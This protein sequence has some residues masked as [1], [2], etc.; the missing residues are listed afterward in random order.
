MS[1]E[2]TPGLP[3][4]WAPPL[5][6]LQQK[7]WAEHPDRVRLEA[8]WDERD[9]NGG[10]EWEQGY[11]DDPDDETWTVLVL[12]TVDPRDTRPNERIGRWPKSVPEDAMARAR[13]I[14]DEHHID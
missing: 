4:D 10:K 8:L 5:R 6:E 2:H 11:E 3:D 13:A 14:V 7:V 9:A 12:R 1:D